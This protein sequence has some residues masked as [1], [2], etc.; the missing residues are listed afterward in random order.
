MSLALAHRVSHR[1]LTRSL[2]HSP[3]RRR[4]YST[5]N[6]PGKQRS[7]HAAWY[8]EMLPGMVP[9]ALLGSAV[10]VVRRRPVPCTGPVR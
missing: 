2:R 4:L 3:A 1:P 8:A 9:I 10:Y 6:A 7:P 5:E